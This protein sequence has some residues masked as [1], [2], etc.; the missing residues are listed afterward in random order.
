MTPTPSAPRR[1]HH[2]HRAAA[3][4]G[5]V[6]DVDPRATV[7]AA[8]ACESSS[9]RS[10][11]AA[12]ALAHRS[13]TLTPASLSSSASSSSSSSSSSYTCSPTTTL[14]SRY[15]TRRPPPPPSSPPSL[16]TLAAAALVVFVL[17]VMA[18]VSVQAAKNKVNI[19]GGSDVSASSTCTA[20]LQCPFAGAHGYCDGTNCSPSKVVDVEIDP[21]GHT[22]WLSL[23]K[24]CGDKPD[25]L[26]E[27]I[28]VNWTKAQEGAVPISSVAIHFGPVKPLNT[29]VILFNGDGDTYGIEAT[30]P[31]T[32]STDGEEYVLD[33]PLPAT[34][35]KFEFTG[36]N[37]GNE[38]LCYV[39][40]DEIK[41][42]TVFETRRFT[43]LSPGFLF[44]L[45]LTVAVL[46]GLG[47]V[48]FMRQRQLAERMGVKIVGTDGYAL[49]QVN[50][51]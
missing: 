37:K 28:L 29:K 11:P 50:S 47:V 31:P 33:E 1:N 49:K 15:R 48:L 20:A 21:H 8:A 25:A 18:A 45:V 41:A 5:H 34:H 3:C 2:P 46:G 38:S 39:V 43:S 12:S 10:A 44:I 17:A 7:A 14:R 4:G 6:V 30:N 22:M 42:F 36:L 40:V 35:V 23:P 27:F 9:W 51:K 24:A 19:A 13:T 32:P 26:S 16:T